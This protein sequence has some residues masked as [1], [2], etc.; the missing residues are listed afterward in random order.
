MGGVPCEVY[1]AEL[2]VWPVDTEIKKKKR[3]EM[4]GPTGLP[5]KQDPLQSICLHPL[6]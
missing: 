4:I 3:K 5:M 6:P 1:N 2:V